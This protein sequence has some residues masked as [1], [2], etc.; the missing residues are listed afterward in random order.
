M[1]GK[2]SWLPVG[3]EEHNSTPLSL[4]ISVISSISDV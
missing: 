1:C 3:F 4:S 2:L